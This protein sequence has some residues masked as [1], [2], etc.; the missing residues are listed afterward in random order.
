MSHEIGCLSKPVTM[1][2]W[3]ADQAWDWPSK[4]RATPSP[5]EAPPTEQPACEAPPHGCWGVC[6]ETAQVLSS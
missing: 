4:A 1:L 3:H 6:S 5:E 2:W